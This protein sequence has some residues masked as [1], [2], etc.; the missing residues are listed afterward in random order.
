MIELPCSVKEVESTHPHPH[1]SHMEVQNTDM[2]TTVTNTNIAKINIWTLVNFYT[3]DYAGLSDISS[4][5]N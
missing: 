4:K 5:N 3:C 1:H 2:K